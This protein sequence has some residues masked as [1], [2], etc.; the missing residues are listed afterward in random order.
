MFEKLHEVR[1]IAKKLLVF[2]ILLS[3]L[4]SVLAYSESAEINAPQGAL[5]VFLDCDRC[6]KDFVRRQIPYVNYV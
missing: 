4:F 3:L 1:A 2:K 5:R 6:D